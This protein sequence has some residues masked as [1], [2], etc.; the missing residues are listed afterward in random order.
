M[1]N[2]PDV[3]DSRSLRKRKSVF[4]TGEA[5]KICKLSQQTIIRCFDNG[6]FGTGGFHVPDSSHRRITSEAL[7]KFMVNNGIPTDAIDA[8]KG[9]RVLTIVQASV[10][11]YI[12]ELLSNE[13]PPCAVEHAKDVFDGGFRY[14]NA[15]RMGKPFDAIVADATI[16]PEETKVKVDE[17]VRVLRFTSQETPTGLELDLSKVVQGIL[18]MREPAQA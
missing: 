8:P 9:R 2:K 14:A 6:D 17:G 4:S 10:R 13:R 7:V 15:K 5:A 11:V 12:E 1:R 16:V 3:S 18:E